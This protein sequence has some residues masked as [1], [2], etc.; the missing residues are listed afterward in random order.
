[1]ITTQGFDPITFLTM[2]S[3]PL[4]GSLYGSVLGILGETDW[5]RRAQVDI[6]GRRFGR[7][8]RQTI[9]P[10]VGVCGHTKLAEA[11]PASTGIYTRD[12]TPWNAASPNTVYLE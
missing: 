7:Y 8:A 12:S 10:G 9:L 11:R 1:M 4:H 6:D 5:L 3:S 2:S